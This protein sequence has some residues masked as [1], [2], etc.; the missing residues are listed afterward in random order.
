MRTPS[1]LLSRLVQHPDDGVNHNPFDLIN[2]TP[3]TGVIEQGREEGG[4]DEGCFLTGKLPGV[5]GKAHGEAHDW[6]ATPSLHKE[7]E[8]R[9]PVPKG[10]L[11]GDTLFLTIKQRTNDNDTLSPTLH[12][13]RTVVVE[14]QKE[15]I[16]VKVTVASSSD[17]LPVVTV[18]NAD[19]LDRCRHADH[20]CRLLKPPSGARPRTASFIGGN[21][22]ETTKEAAATAAPMAEDASMPTPRAGQRV[23]LHS[24]VHNADMNGL[25]GT[26]TKVESSGRLA[27]RIDGGLRDKSFKPLNVRL[28]GVEG[29]GCGAGGSGCGAGEGGA[30]GAEGGTGGAKGRVRIV[31]EAPRQK[32]SGSGPGAAAQQPPCGDVKRRRT[33]NES[34]DERGAD[35]SVPMRTP[36]SAHPPSSSNQVPPSARAASQSAACGGGL[37]L[38]SA[39]EGGAGMADDEADDEADFIARYLAFRQFVEVLRSG[40]SKYARTQP[41]KILVRRSNPARS[42]LD[43]FSMGATKAHAWQV[44]RVAF[45][46]GDG[47]KEEGVD[48]GGLTSEMYTLLFRELTRGSNELFEGTPQ[49]VG[50]LPRATAPA[51]EL[52]A[53]GRVLRKCVLDDRPVGLGFGRFLFDYLADAHERS[54][55][56]SAASALSALTD[57]DPDLAARWTRLLAKPVEGLTQSDFDGGPSDAPLPA[58]APHFQRAIVAGCRYMLLG[59]R[60]ASLQAIRRGFAEHVDLSIQLAACN[61]SHRARML[62]GK[63]EIGPKELLA[64]FAMPPLLQLAHDPGGVVSHAPRFLRTV[65]EERLNASERLDL[66]EWATALRALPANGL[67]TRIQLRPYHGAT[68]VDLPMVHTCTHEVH[69][70]PYSSCDVLE[71]KLRRAVA[72]RNDGFHIE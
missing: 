52:C 27:V 38:Y 45:E 13:R 16:H 14:K 22:A 70:P 58:S 25:L 10:A 7:V 46:D 62:R 9:V 40:V 71:E 29:G 11:E 49:G 4:R 53:V 47:G 63:V 55:F 42:V 28:A 37:G 56:V 36:S 30:G 26:V 1:V 72:H 43:A 6:M 34:A 44:T 67:Q 15:E 23:V 33:S 57:Y 65:V 64:C 20:P 32:S 69:L 3:T 66:L 54:V 18:D 24:F 59:C 35:S 68:D 21:A 19:N 61:P 48:E 5:H 31:R 12:S 60:E 51:D 2:A 41:W 50:L 17:A 8:V 39:G